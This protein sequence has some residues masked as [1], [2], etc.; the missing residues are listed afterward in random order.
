MTTVALT[1]QSITTGA[2]RMIGFLVASVSE[3]P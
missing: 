3:T 1:E 2:I